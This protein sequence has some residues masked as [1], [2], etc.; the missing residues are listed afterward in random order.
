MSNQFAPEGYQTVIPYL[1]LPGALKFQEFMQQVF[2]AEQ[3]H[4]VMADGDRVRHGQVKVGDSTIMFADSSDQFPVQNAG[5]F[6]YVENADKTYDNAIAAGAA[7]IM[8]PA[9]QPYGRSCGVTDPFG[10]TW[11]I[12]SVAKTTK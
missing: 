10:N 5:M 4:Q 6:V 7:S 2:N 12:T 9:D 11:W 3:T 1:I 8:P